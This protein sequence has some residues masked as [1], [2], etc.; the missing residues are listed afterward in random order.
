[1]PVVVSTWSIDTV[2]A[3]SWLSVFSETMGGRA[4]RLATSMLMGVQI[5]PRAH[6][7]M[8]LTFSVVANSA[9]Q[10][11]S[12]SFSRSGSSTHMITLPARRS[13]SASSMLLNP[14]FMVGRPF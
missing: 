2:K 5:S 9:A 13:S 4:R 7:A 10:M 12:P 3:V 1:M 6:T 11:K 8:R 14:L